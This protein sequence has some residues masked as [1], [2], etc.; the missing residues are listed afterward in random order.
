LAVALLFDEKIRQGAALF[1]FGLWDVGILHKLYFRAAIKRTIVDSPTLLEHGSAEKIVCA[2][3]TSDPN[4]H[5]N[6]QN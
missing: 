5:S 1:W 4:K 3:T 6:I 2:H